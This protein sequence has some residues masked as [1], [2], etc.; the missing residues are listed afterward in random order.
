MKE[1]TL[2]RRIEFLKTVPL[3]VGLGDADLNTLAGD[4]RPK[5]YRPGDYIFHQGDYSRELYVVT[6]GKVRV[7]RVS[8]AG[9]ETSIQVFGPRD[10]VGEF[11]T[12][13]GQPRSAAAKAIGPSIVLEI[14]GELFLQRMREMPDL[15][16]GMTRL[17]ATKVRWT[18]AYAET[19]AQ[20]DAAGRLLHILLLYNEQF[21]QPV[22]PGGH[23]R[24]DLGLDQS[25]LASLVGARREWVNRILRDWRARGLI[26]YEAGRIT[27][28]DLPR[29]VAERD[30]RAEGNQLEPPVD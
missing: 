16:L 18:A 27:I 28:L 23:Y 10:I 26:E 14:R 1:D 12:I 5:N 24:L 19:I 20:Y 2:P 3:F 22:E 15:A 29:V 21:G 11:A 6:Q 8:Q 13:D 4:F 7:F 25:D 9:G 30:Q 17:L